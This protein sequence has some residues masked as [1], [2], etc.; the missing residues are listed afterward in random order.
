[1][2]LIVNNAGAQKWKLKQYKAFPDYAS[3]SAIAWYKNTL[4][5]MGDDAPTILLLNR[6]LRE[7]QQVRVF[8]VQQKRIPYAEKPD[9]ESATVVQKGK[10]DYLWLLPSFSSTGRNKA[11]TLNLQQKN[12]K[13]EVH[14]LTLGNA[15]LP[16]T[17]IEGAAII[18]E[19]LLLA[20]RANS[21]SPAHHLLQY[22]LEGN[23]FSK[24]PVRSFTLNLPQTAHVVGVSGL[25]YEPKKDILLLTFST[26]LTGSATA[27]GAIGDSYIALIKNA[28]AQIE[29]NSLKAD[30]L[31]N[32][33]PVLKT[34]K[35]MKIES[36]AVQKVRGST[37]RLFLAADNDDGTSHLFRISARLPR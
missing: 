26:E 33:T 19:K 1:M 13:P 18:G 15:G 16:H 31:I 9:I 12:A 30:T 2:L 36:V 7:Q 6:R 21:Q 8:S 4:Y 24:K 34:G 3:A 32:L 17:N 5:V 27:D 11:I 29:N 22:Q 14:I 10:E 25:H 35:P 28:R 23:N 20:N 37:L